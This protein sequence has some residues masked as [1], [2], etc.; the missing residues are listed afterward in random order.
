[1]EK[2]RSSILSTG[3]GP[4]ILHHKNISFF[5]YLTQVLEFQLDSSGSGEEPGAGSC[6]HGK[7]PSDSQKAGNFLTWWEAVKYSDLYISGRH[8]YFGVFHTL[9]V[10]NIKTHSHMCNFIHS[11]KKTNTLISSY[12]FYPWA[13]AYAEITDREFKKSLL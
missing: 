9:T 8:E 12:R 4:T 3:R 5:R 2:A 10:K 6:E 13:V 1:M 11:D 7:E